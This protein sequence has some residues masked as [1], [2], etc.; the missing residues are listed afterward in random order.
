MLAD[1]DF[2]KWRMT[3]LL[4][5]NDIS[6]IH[7][8]TLQQLSY[9]SDFKNELRCVIKTRST[10]GAQDSYKNFEFTND[11]FDARIQS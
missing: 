1:H 7:P 10:P 11:R 4:A 2:N 3:I 5:V 8:L 6:D 9:L